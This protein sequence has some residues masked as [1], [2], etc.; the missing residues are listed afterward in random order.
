MK[1]QDKNK[2]RINMISSIRAKI[3]TSIIS[4]VII[5]VIIIMYTILPVSKQLIS[6]TT[7]SYMLNMAASNR[8]ILE[9]SLQEGQ[10]LAAQYTS[11]LSHVKVDNAPNSYA[12]LVGQDGMMKYHPTADKIGSVVENE[13]VKGLVATIQSGEIPSDNVIT[14]NYKGVLKYASYAI[15]KDKDILVITA[16]EDEIMKPINDIKKTAIMISIVAVII[17]GLYGFMV[18]I[19]IVRP[20]KQ[21]T[22]IIHNTATFNFKHSKYSERLCKRPDETGEMAR[23]VRQMRG[24]LRQ[25]VQKIEDAQENITTSV[26][27]L[28]GVIYEVNQMSS[29]NSATTQ[30]LAAGMEETAATTETIFEDIRNIQNESKGINERSEEGSIRSKEIMNRANSL[31]LTTQTASN[32][33]KEIYQS[34]QVKSDKAIADS[35]AV[36]KINV[37]TNAI[38]S[39]SSQTSLL[40]LNASIEAARAGEAG[41]GFA[42]VANEIGKLAEQT[43]KQVS[44]IDTV[45]GEVNQAVLNM[46]ECLE[47]TAQ[48]LGTTVLKDYMEFTKVGEQYNE[49]ALVFESSMNDIHQKVEALTHSINSIAKALS[50][51][52][53]TV[54]ES[55]SGITDIAEKTADMVTK[56]NESNSLAEASFESTTEL[57]NIVNQFVLS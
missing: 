45:V 24:S 21:L 19:F 47:E 52:N 37:L 4:S 6:S 34:V 51:I 56:A 12:Y 50:G 28:Q 22:E 57:K 43:S 2:N 53:D 32:K 7:K 16:D 23:A 8:T 27:S 39:I 55:S 5:A 30:E 15:T 31:L 29:D 46:S 17:M 41:K 38:M 48:F 9:K 25:I 1:D 11:L 33:T 3:V 13:V 35:K 20:I 14:Y 44:S 36:E 54:S 42:V 40:A 10:D 26:S 18:G 49:D